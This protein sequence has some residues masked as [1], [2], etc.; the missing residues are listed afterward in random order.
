MG[1]GKTT[2]GRHLSGA[3]GW[4]LRD[5]DAELGASQGRTAADIYRDEGSAAV[6]AREAAVLRAH[7]AANGPSVIAAAASV[8]EDPPTVDALA[9]PT[10]LVV[11][12][13]GTPETLVRRATGSDHR[14]WH[15]RA[16]LDHLRERALVRDPVYGR[17]ARVVIDTETTPPSAAA[18]AIATAIRAQ[19]GETA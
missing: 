7:L 15:G 13:R 11:W 10:V 16:P 18:A 9:D 14:P 8:V 6:H 12:L 3:L 4:P 2:V 17:L 1:A 19:A 5:S